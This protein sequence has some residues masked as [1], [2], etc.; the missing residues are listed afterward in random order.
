[1]LESNTCIA[2]VLY[3]H[4]RECKK[5]KA[6]FKLIFGLNFQFLPTRQGFI[7]AIL[8]SVRQHKKLNLLIE[9]SNLIFTNFILKHVG[10]ELAFKMN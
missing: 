6:N 5:I 8:I 10:I 2:E 7:Q 1:M 4:P 3:S 9:F